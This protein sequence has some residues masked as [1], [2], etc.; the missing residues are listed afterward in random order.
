MKIRERLL[1]GE[2]TAF[3]VQKTYD[4]TSV[5]KQAKA[6][7]SRG[8]APGENTLV[9]RIPRSLF[10]AYLKQHGVRWDDP[11]AEDLKARFLMERDYSQFRVT[12]GN[13]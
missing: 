8:A 3:H 2:G 6:L 1:Y 10:A 7:A 13:I 12:E 4:Y 11:A 9:A 5:L